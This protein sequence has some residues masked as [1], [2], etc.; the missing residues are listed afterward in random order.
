M[1]PLS[2]RIYVGARGKKSLW[3]RQAIRPGGCE[4]RVGKFTI[5]GE[6][7]WILNVELLFLKF[8]GSNR[9]GCAGIFFIIALLK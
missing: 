8:Y 1:L 6:Y 4:G 9:T 5:N 3:H 2:C 7:A